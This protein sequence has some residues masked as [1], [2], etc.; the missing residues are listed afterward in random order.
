MKLR[1]TEKALADVLAIYDYIAAQAPGYADVVSERIL[2]RPEQLIDQPHSGSVQST[3]ERRFVSCSCILSAS[4]IGCWFGS[5]DPDG[6][7]RQP[8]FA[9]RSVGSA[10]AMTCA[11]GRLAAFFELDSQ[12]SV[13]RNVWRYPI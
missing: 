4:S 8:P 12:L 9:T 13:S 5:T 3:A 6:G 2:S 10:R 11:G 1:W 7:P